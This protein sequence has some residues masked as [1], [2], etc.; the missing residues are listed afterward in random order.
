[1][2]RS[3][4][5]R[6]HGPGAS[7]AVVAAVRTQ[8]RGFTFQCFPSCFCSLRGVVSCVDARARGVCVASCCLGTCFVHGP[9]CGCGS[10]V[11]F[12]KR[13]ACLYCL[14]NRWRSPAADEN[15]YLCCVRARVCNPHHRDLSARSGGTNAVH[16]VRPNRRLRGKPRTHGA[17]FWRGA[18][19]MVHWV[20]P[21][22][23]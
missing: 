7:S 10:L 14:K 17:A 1:M 5:Q 4:L 20:G 23:M 19:H 6:A 3:L 2:S 11:W 8:G 16:K 18:S 15:K 21:C 13:G 22:R 9:S 12:Y